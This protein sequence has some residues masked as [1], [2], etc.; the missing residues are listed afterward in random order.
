MTKA[1]KSLPLSSYR[2][3]DTWIRY[4][5]WFAGTSTSA[6]APDSEGHRAASLPTNSRSLSTAATLPSRS[7]PRSWLRAM[8]SGNVF[9]PSRARGLSATKDQV[10]CNHLRVPGEV[11]GGFRPRCLRRQTSHSRHPRVSRTSHSGAR[12]RGN[13][14]TRRGETAE[15]LR[16]ERK[17]GS[18]YGR[19]RENSKR[20]V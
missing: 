18:T 17:R 2:Y 16:L 19:Q 20:T 11:S 15:K 5:V 10:R 6:A 4:D 13:V 9:V 14:I 8:T 12:S 3:V 1:R 7:S